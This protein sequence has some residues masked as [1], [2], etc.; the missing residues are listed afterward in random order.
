M[1]KCVS[2]IVKQTYPRSSDTDNTIM[3]K[4]ALIEAKASFGP[5]VEVRRICE[6]AGALYYLVIA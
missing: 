3:D 5:L 2:V 6:M 1:K 4:E